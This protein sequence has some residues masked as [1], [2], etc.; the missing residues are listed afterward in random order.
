MRLRINHLGIVVHNIE[1]SLKAYLED[2]GFRQISSIITIENQGVRV[3]VLRNEINNVNIELIEPW[4]EN[5]PVLNFLAR[6]GGINHICYETEDFE[7]VLRKFGN[8]V[9][10]KPSPTPVEYFN[11]GRTVFIHRHG[12]LIEFLEKKTG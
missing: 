12:E 1:K 2:Y 11:G 8:K 3:V 6:G 9:V 7:E 10:R 4:G 5:S